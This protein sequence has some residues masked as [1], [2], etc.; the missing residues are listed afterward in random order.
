[1]GEFMIAA[2]V[3]DAGLMSL[4]SMSAYANLSY[5][6]KLLNMPEGSYQMLSFFLPDMK[7]LDRDGAVY[8]DALKARAP[9]FERDSGQNRQQ[10]IMK[11]LRGDKTDMWEG[12]RY[13][14]QTLNDTLSSLQDL[15]NGINIAR[16][17]ALGVLFL[18]IMVGI[19]NTFR[20]IMLDR[21]R[22]IGTMR[23]LGMQ[24]G[25]VLSLFLNE[26]VFLSLGGAVAGL[27]LGLV[28]MFAFSLYNFGIDSMFA[29]LLKNGHLTFNL[30]PL[31]VLA[32]ILI[33]G[34]LTLFA[35]L[36]PARMAARLEPAQAL[37]T[38]K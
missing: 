15:V 7:N 24:K 8:Y 34:G 22:E 13:R 11:R 20:M 26:A 37:R 35:A 1:M 10:E 5:V 16:F 18:V 27:L 6:N 25:Q 2:I 3:H 23:A 30:N 32:N 19:T 14:M 4:S 9:V 29:M 17:I 21:I 33:I 28:V 36:I 12:T 31:M 38:A